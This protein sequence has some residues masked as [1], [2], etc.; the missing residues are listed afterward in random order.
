MRLRWMLVLGACTLQPGQGAHLVVEWQLR[1]NS[2]Q[3]RCGVGLGGVAVAQRAGRLLGE[4][5][6]LQH[7]SSVE[8]HLRMALQAIIMQS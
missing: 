2:V 4:E 7:S 5:A 6:V 1:S 8:A 3:G